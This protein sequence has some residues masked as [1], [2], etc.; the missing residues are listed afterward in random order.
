MNDTSNTESKDAKGKKAQ[1]IRDLYKRE[2]RGE[3]ASI[4]IMGLFGTGKTRLLASGRRPLLVDSF[5]PNGTLIL[6][7][8]YKEDIEKGDILIRTFWN[9]KSTK[10]TEYN[11]WERQWEDDIR[12]GF[13]DSFGTYAIDSLTT[14][15]DAMSNKVSKLKGREEGSLAIQDYKIIYNSLKDIIKLSSSCDTDFVLTAH[16]ADERDEIT[17][18]VISQ[19]AVYNKL[20]AEIPLLFT[21][22]W[23]LVNQPGS[24]GVKRILL[25]EDYKTY[26]ASTQLGANGTF[27]PKEEPNLLELLKKAGFKTDPKPSLFDD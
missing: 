5:D 3:T 20:K 17:G 8:L 2:K 22:K 4:L 6:E 26:R 25:T 1:D 13:L 24:D 12:T 7:R 16:L 15:L 9:E 21:E 19:L 14:F 23:V 27:K 10:P 18:K 11:K